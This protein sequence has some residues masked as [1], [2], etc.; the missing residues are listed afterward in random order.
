MDL[1]LADVPHYLAVIQSLVDV[2]E[3]HSHDHV[4]HSHH[5]HKRN[6]ALCSVGSFLDGDSFYVWYDCFHFL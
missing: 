1:Q 2:H 3:H 4:Y 5:C 6:V